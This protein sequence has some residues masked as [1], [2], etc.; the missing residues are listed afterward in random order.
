MA[1][2]YFKRFRMEIDL[3]RCQPIGPDLPGEYRMVPWSRHLVRCHAE[4]K[5]RSFR[6]EVDANV[7]PC[8]GEQSGC[9]RLMDEIRHKEGFLP[10]ATWLAE[11]IGDG[12]DK[13][14]FCGTVQGVRAAGG[15][16]GIQNLGVTPQHRRQGLGT[17]LMDWA[18]AGF[19]RAGLRRA[20]L[21]VTAQNEAAVQLYRQMGFTRVRTLYKA[22][23]VICT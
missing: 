12:A 13:R 8:L 5:Y 20:Y 17:I 10:A 15:Y 1:L 9:V 6:C 11:Y 16:G 21:E 18:L 19:R 3:A 23:E 22:V 4:A 2:T 14:E 7:F